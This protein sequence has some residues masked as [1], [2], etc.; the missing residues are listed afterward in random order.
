MAAEKSKMQEIR[1]TP[2]GHPV[3]IFQDA[4]VARMYACS[5]CKCV[6]RDC[7]E[8]TCDEHNIDRAHPNADS[9]DDNSQ[10][11][12]DEDDDEVHMYCLQCLQHYL[13]QHDNK[14]PVKVSHSHVCKFAPNKLIR[15]QIRN[16][17]I[18]CPN[19]TAANQERDME[20]KEE[21]T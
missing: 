1:E 4:L 17:K 16:A 19:S 5:L 21:S 20:R 2:K 7:V 9:N 6:T 13:K 14:C 10:S 12:T 8:L 18:T 3:F 11:D 15:R